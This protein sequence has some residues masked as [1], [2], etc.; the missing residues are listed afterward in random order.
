MTLA[1]LQAEAAATEAC[2]VIKEVAEKLW[3]VVPERSKDYISRPKSNGYRSVHLT[4]RINSIV[5][6]QVGC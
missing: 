1:S 5:L 2:F 3:H 4:V 6:E